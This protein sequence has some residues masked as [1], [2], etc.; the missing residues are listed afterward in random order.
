M[1]FMNC[2]DTLGD[3]LQRF[4]AFFEDPNLFL[5]AVNVMEKKCTFQSLSSKLWKKR[6][7]FGFYLNIRGSLFATC[8]MGFGWTGSTDWTGGIASTGGTGSTTSTPT[9]S[10]FIGRGITGFIL[11]AFFF[12]LLCIRKFCNV[13]TKYVLQNVPALFK[14]CVHTD[15]L[16]LNNRIISR[17]IYTEFGGNSEIIFFKKRCLLNTF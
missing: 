2:N 12:K 7:Y 4:Y 9:G 15:S 14:R 17:D 5:K 16:S 13:L 11:N 1:H 6:N 3:E 10:S 8:L